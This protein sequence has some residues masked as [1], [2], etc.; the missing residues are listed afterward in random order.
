[1]AQD[2]IEPLRHARE[3]R[4]Q[5]GCK[6]ALHRP[7]AIDA[8]AQRHILGNAAV[9]HHHMLADKGKLRAQAGQVPVMNIMAIECD[10]ARAQV[11]ES[12]QQIDQRGLA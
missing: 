4:S 5:V 10:V 6:Q 7:F 1:M 3:Q 9:E 11:Y 12:G 8:L 2:G